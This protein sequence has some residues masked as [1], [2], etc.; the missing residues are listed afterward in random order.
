MTKDELIAAMADV[1]GDTQ[2]CLAEAEW[3]ELYRVGTVR[4]TVVIDQLD[5]KKRPRFIEILPGMGTTEE[6]RT[7]LVIE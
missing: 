1:P 6:K 4:K 3:G 7:V 2:V 5:H